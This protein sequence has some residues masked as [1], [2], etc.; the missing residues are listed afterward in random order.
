MSD[1]NLSIILGI[2]LGLVYGA[3]ILYFAL[4]GMIID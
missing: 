3:I 2:L 4:G 1:R